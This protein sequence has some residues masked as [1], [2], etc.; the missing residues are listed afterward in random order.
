LQTAKAKGVA[1]ERSS[2]D[3]REFRIPPN[4]SDFEAAMA[5]FEFLDLPLVSPPAKGQVRRDRQGNVAFDLYSMNGPRHVTLL[6]KENLIRIE[7]RRN[8]LPR[9]IDNLHTTTIGTGSRDLRVRM[10]SWYNEFAIWSLIFMAASGVWLWISSRPGC[11]WARISFA[12]GS[13]AFLLLYFLT[14]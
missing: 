12:T 5:A 1:S 13:G 8:I 9:Y 14:R 7:T 10:W 2:G 11:L 4:T 6:E 3:T